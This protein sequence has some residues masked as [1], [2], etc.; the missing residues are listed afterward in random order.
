MIFVIQMGESFWQKD[1]LI[2]HILCELCLF[3]NLA[4]CTFFCSP[5]IIY[6]RAGDHCWCRSWCLER[7][8]YKRQNDLWSLGEKLLRDGGLR[9]SISEKSSC[10]LWYVLLFFIISGHSKGQLISKCLYGVIVWTKKTT[11][12]FP[13]FLP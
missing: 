2:T 12:F 10:L 1:S 11:N 3:R 4:Q 8:S 9:Y 6:Y 5:S 7:S 13:G